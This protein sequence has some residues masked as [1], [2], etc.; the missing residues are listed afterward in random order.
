MSCDHP[1][2]STTQV[3]ILVMSPEGRT[4]NRTTG[5]VC[6]KC[7]EFIGTVDNKG[8]RQ[9]LPLELPEYA[10]SGCDHPE[11]SVEKRQYKAV[12]ASKRRIIVGLGDP[13]YCSKCESP[14][15]PVKIRF[16][17]EK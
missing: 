11:E 15:E 16:N 2:H 6:E 3:K 14:V 9:T 10:N 4:Y 17:P 5:V 8:E 13:R 7:S 12:L 1:Y